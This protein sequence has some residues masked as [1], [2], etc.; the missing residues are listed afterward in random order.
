MRRLLLIVALLAGLLSAGLT[1]AALAADVTANLFAVAT[2]GS[3][4]CARSEIPITFSQ[5]SVSGAVCGYGPNETSWDTACDAATGSDVVGVMP[6]V[7]RT[8]GG[9]GYLLGSNQIGQDCTDGLG[10]DVNPNAREQK[11]ATG[12][13]AYWTKFIPGVA[14]NGSPNISFQYAGSSILSIANGNW[15]LIV[16][17]DCFN[18]NRTLYIFDRNINAGPGGRPQNLIFRG[19]SKT[20]LQ[21]WYGI[22]IRGARNILMENIDYG[23]NVQCAANDANANPAYF[24]CNPSGPY[25]EAPYAT[26]GTNAPGCAPGPS[27]LC[28]GF[29]S[30]GGNEFVEPY[31]HGG[32]GYGAYTNI[33]LQ[34]FRL[35]DGQA[36]GTGSGIHPGCFMFDGM[37]GIG[38]LPPHN[39]VFD[40]VSCE[41]QVI[42]VQHLDSGVTVQNSYFG[43]PVLGLSQTSP[44]GRWDVCSEGQPEVGVACRTDYSPGC[45]ASNIL[46][47]YNVF[48]PG[49]NAAGL[50]F[51][52]GSPFGGFSNVR[53]VGNIFMGSG[54][55]G[56]SIAGI[57][58]DRNSFL[59]VG[60]AG[61]N[62]TTL[63]CDP[64][65]DSEQ[66]T[67]DDLWRE[68]TQL[69]PR[70][71]GADCGV[72]TL[73][74]SA[75]GPDFQLGWD[76][77][78][79]ARSATATKAGADHGAGDAP[80]P[81]PPPPPPPT[82]TEPPPTT[83]EP[84]PPPAT[85][86]SDGADNDG[87]GHTDMGD[88]DCSSLQDDSEAAA[89]PP[90]PPP[91]AD[92]APTCEPTCDEQIADLEDQVAAAKAD[93]RSLAEQVAALEARVSAL[94]A[95]LSAANAEKARLGGIID[96]IAAE[97]AT[98]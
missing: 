14:C 41:R 89:P 32:A 30:R 38:G 95:D 13:T 60:T 31:I 84:P 8:V 35:H 25:F 75:L 15:H 9:G 3:P 96:R 11:V 2:G 79:D 66:G 77:D 39:M 4:D 88:P 68:S 69:D 74:P 67:P 55:S 45:T 92:Y 10:A 54:L 94:Q 22:E 46:Y 62:A 64:F 27:G 48:F 7:Y 93:A 34:N 44:Q 19:E 61:A 73:D 80:P 85:Q 36:K 86:C 72:P 26:F 43:C 78:G 57:T 56:C 50:A 98:K 23:P 47:R 49:F 81:P 24:R 91:P 5:A 42:G 63:T 12:T 51:R 58:C 29:F 76:G 37:G 1:P 20:R 65:V 52:S 28:A 40:G 16:E 97:A 87:D 21:S 59:N 53:A 82:T 18:F 6:G 17:G 90:P 33:R 71:S 70:L 83:T